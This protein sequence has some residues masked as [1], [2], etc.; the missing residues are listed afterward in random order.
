MSLPASP[1]LL[2]RIFDLPTPTISNTTNTKHIVCESLN[3]PGAHFASNHLSSQAPTALL[4]HHIQS[5]LSRLIT[6]N[7]RSSITIPRPQSI[8][9]D[10]IIPPGS[11]APNHAHAPY[12]CRATNQTHDIYLPRQRDIRVILAN[13]SLLE[14]I[15]ICMYC[16]TVI[17][18]KAG[19]LASLHSTAEGNSVWGKYTDGR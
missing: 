19:S 15:H 5:R 11:R 9:T 4:L 10:K 18:H 1:S 3:M 14:V 6:L 17:Y 2:Q 8:Q 7:H 13:T 12:G 16:A